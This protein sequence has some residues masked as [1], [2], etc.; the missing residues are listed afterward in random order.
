MDPK[1]VLV[2]G[3][4]G[5]IGSHLVDALVA[6]GHQ[7]AVVDDLSAGSR[8]NLNSQA[9][10]Y[11]GSITDSRLLDR[12]FQ[13]VAPQWVSH[14][15]AQISVARSVEDPISDA[16]V[17]VVGSVALMEACHRSGVEHMVF[18]ST[19]GALYGDPERLPCDESA[20]IRPLSP[21][22]AAKCAVETYLTVY[23]QTWGLKSVA[24]RYGNVYG[25]RQ[26]PLGEAGVIAIFAHKM[27]AGE[28]PTIFGSGGQTRD[29][30]YV[31][32]LVEANML[33]M[34]RQLEG[35]YNVGSG[36]ESSVN[37]VLELLRRSCG[38]EGPVTYA[39]ERPGEVQRMVLDSGR[40]MGQA[41]WSPQVSLEEG[42]RSTVDYFRREAPA[43]LP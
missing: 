40:F 30:V 39:P 28:Q 42:V 31:G 10:F 26:S 29:F 34:E 19:G 3:G 7:V 23:R 27:L 15:A 43:T 2:T 18:A 17:G 38:Y 16:Q 5:F 33:A 20:P 12:V 11:A 14:H 36:V 37:R 21:Y 41:G 9:A 4:A 8:D 22:A 35:A 25:P 13:E 32:D 6:R 24:L 1:R